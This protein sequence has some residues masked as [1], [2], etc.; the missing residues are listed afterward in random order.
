[1]DRRI[2]NTR[3]SESII[4]DADDYDRVSRHLW[5][6]NSGYVMSKI[7]NKKVLLHR[8]ILNYYG[9]DDVDHINGNALD[10]RKINLRICSHI[11]NMRNSKRYSNNK[12]G[13]KGVH[14]YGNRFAVSIRINKKLKHL[15]YFDDVE[16]ASLAYENKAKEVFGE[17]YRDE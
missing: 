9:K 5:H 2:I 17:F 4:I 11:E 15:G 16:S 7:Q 13:Y 1:M 10:N 14:T 3:K 12:T 8:F 6:I